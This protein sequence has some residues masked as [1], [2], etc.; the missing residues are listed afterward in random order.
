MVDE[1]SRL[2]AV[3]GFLPHGYCISWSPA[4]LATYVI[5]D[6][7]IFLSYF[8]MPVALGYFARRRPDFPYRWLLWMFAAFILVCGTTHLMGTIVL[9]MPVYWLDALIK[10]ATAVVSAVTAVVLWPL[11]PHALRLPSPTQLQAANEELR[12][13][14]AERQRAEAELQVAKEA[15][16]QATRAKSEFLANMS[17]ELRTP[18]NAII[19]FSEVL[20]DGLLGGMTAEQTEYVTDIFGSGQHLLSLI[21]DILDLSKIEAGKMALDLEALDV[22]TMLGN[23]LSIIKEKSAAHGIQLQLDEPEPL[24]TALLDGRK[25]K[26]IVY[27]LLSNSVKFTPEGGSVRLRARK[28]T[29]SH[30]ENWT[31]PEA[32]RLRM[33]LPP[34]D[35]TEFLELVA[36]DTGIGIAPADAPRLFRAF[37]Q[38]DSSLSRATEGTGLGLALVLKLAQLHGGTVALASTP[39]QGSR[40]TVWLPWRQARAARADAAATAESPTLPRAGRRL[41]L[42]IEDNDRAAE[43]VRLQLEPEGFDIV[44]A[45]SAKDGLDLLAKQRPAVIILDIILPDMD[46]WALLAQIKQQGAPSAGVP[47]VIASIVA[48]QHKGFSLGAS[49]VL[50]KPVS[51]ED[52]VATLDGLGLVRANRSIKVLV[53]DDDPKAVELL[54]AY[55]A[56][57]GYTVLRAY[58]GSEGIAVARRERPDL[59][60]LDLMMPEVNGFDV[61]EALRSGAETA[62]I[63]IVVVTAKTLT[64]EDRAVLNGYVASILEKASFSHGRFAEEVQRAL[65]INRNRES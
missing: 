47:V 24:G 16:E 49:A 34:G 65:A 57:P 25:T 3:N 12:R 14:I 20:K 52:L 11:L 22:D 28:V 23:S 4:L 27:N 2:L 19:G 38:V 46:G 40:F 30:I 29:R 21:N 5:S 1:L 6:S 56:E 55:L 26:Q 51:R 35:F 60:V 39:G 36:E 58:G 48:D 44:R 33:P 59:L 54:A 42:V 9:W 37:S 43:L 13:E 63:P 62:A 64:A 41:A 18:L 53:V 61:V 45:A 7:V 10:A 32:T 15:A 17:H 8:S 50:Q 31:A